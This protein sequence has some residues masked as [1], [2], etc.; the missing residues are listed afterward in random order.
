MSDLAL[1][2]WEIRQ[3]GGEW[4]SFVEWLANATPEQCESIAR[5]LPSL[6]KKYGLEVAEGES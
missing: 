2:A 4:C 5:C 3:A 6:A 1:Q